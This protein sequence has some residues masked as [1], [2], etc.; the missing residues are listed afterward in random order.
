M[1]DRTRA[2]E[3]AVVSEWRTSREIAEE[4]GLDG[5]EGAR[6]TRTV[7]RRLV[8]QGRAERSERVVDTPLGPRTA[9][10]WRRKP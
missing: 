1:T 7:L 6:A 4:A 8:R 2:I 10:A 5:I 9:A 3:A